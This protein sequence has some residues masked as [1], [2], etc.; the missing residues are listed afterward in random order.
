MVLYFTVIE[1]SCFRVIAEQRRGAGRRKEIKEKRTE[2]PKM[3]EA[4]AGR[5]RRR[6]GRIKDVEDEKEKVVKEKDA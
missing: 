6:K 5:G 4:T 3:E 1:K 2:R